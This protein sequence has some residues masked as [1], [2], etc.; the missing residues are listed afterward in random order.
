MEKTLAR[1]AVLTVVVGVMGMTV[2]RLQAAQVVGG[3][4]VMTSLMPWLWLAVFVVAVVAMVFAAGWPARIV[5][6]VALLVVIC[7]NWLIDLT[8]LTNGADPI[9]GSGTVMFAGLVA[10]GVLM[11]TAVSVGRHRHRTVVETAVLI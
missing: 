4:E 10:A 6:C 3:L 1:N 2:V 9:A 8:V 7:C 5:A 11:R